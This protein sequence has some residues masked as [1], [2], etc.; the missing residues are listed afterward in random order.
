[1]VRPICP[2]SQPVE[3]LDRCSAEDSDQRLVVG[4][5]LE[6]PQAAPEKPST[7]TPSVLEGLAAERL[8]NP[9]SA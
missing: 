3:A 1:M 2:K 7:R 9:R 5:H 4:L 8:G 6:V